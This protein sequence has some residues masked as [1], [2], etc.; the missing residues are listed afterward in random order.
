M[1]LVSR[2]LGVIVLREK[3]DIPLTRDVGVSQKARLQLKLVIDARLDWTA[4]AP[5]APVADRAGQPCH[6]DVLEDEG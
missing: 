3:V 1:F 5:F 6:I 4:M 2:T